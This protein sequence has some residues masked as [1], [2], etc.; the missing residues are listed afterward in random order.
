MI[1]TNESQLS[2]VNIIQPGTKKKKGRRKGRKKPVEPQ[3]VSE[4]TELPL[5]D[6]ELPKWA[7]RSMREL[8]K[9]VIVVTDE[10]EEG[11]EPNEWE[12][13]SIATDMLRESLGELPGRDE[14]EEDGFEEGE[15]AIEVQRLKEDLVGRLGQE[16]FEMLVENLEHEGLDSAREFLDIMNDDDP[17]AVRDAR[18]MLD[19]E[20]VDSD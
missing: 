4:D 17:E 16:L 5:P 11:S 14:L 18:R 10:G 2:S 13:L 19:L 1:K 15:A 6:E 3:L 12:E 20:R 9:G 7:Q 8:K